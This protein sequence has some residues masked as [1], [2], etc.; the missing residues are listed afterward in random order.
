MSGLETV[1][2]RA[3]SSAAPVLL[4]TPEARNTV[5]ERKTGPAGA[6]SSLP[7]SYG[8]KQ[9]PRTALDLGEN[10]FNHQIQNEES[11]LLTQGGRLVRG[12]R[13]RQWP[14]LERLYLDRL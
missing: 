12:L 11:K 9:Q 13:P 1:N 7:P 5:G 8:P 3:C 14:L 10:A 6:G 2:V 4:G